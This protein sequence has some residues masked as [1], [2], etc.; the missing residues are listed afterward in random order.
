MVRRILMIAVLVAMVG[1]P[2]L[3]LPVLAHHGSAAWGPNE[4][5]ENGTIVSF[6][7]RNPHVLVVYNVKDANGN[8]VQWTGELNSPETEQQQNGLTKDSLKAGEEVIVFGHPAKNGAHN[9]LIT[10]INRP[11]GTNVV[12]SPKT[13][14]PGQNLGQE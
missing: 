6:L 3:N 14:Q 10:R 9:S 2:L 4:V 13:G 1:F 7:W 5:K 11:D 12:L 8:V